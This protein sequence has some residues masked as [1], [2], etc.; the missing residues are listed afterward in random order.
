MQ[1]NYF[2]RV[3]QQTPTRLWVNNPNLDGINKALAIGALNATTN[4]AYCSKLL[5]SEPEYFHSVINQIVKE[6]DDD[7]V[8]ADL[9]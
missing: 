5:Q 3:M 1:P 6:T 8:A 2:N 9:A 4:P 7:D